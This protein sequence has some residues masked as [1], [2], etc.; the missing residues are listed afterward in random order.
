M[1]DTPNQLPHIGVVAVVGLVDV[2][3]DRRVDTTLGGDGPLL[4]HVGTAHQLGADVIAEGL[5][6]GDL[7]RNKRCHPL[8]VA[9]VGVRN[10]D[11]VPA[12]VILNQLLSKGVDCTLE[13]SLLRVHMQHA[14]GDSGNFGKALDVCRELFKYL[15]VV[16]SHT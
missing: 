12:V 10:D 13:V 7:V 3:P 8:Q 16:F 1:T 15:Q 4:E 5:G 6:G 11:A 2:F 9:L 14:V